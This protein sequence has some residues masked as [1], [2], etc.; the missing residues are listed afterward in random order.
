MLRKSLIVVWILVILGHRRWEKST[1]QIDE[2]LIFL[3]RRERCVQRGKDLGWIL[4]NMIVENEYMI[5][6]FKLIGDAK[7]WWKEWCWEQPIKGSIIT[8]KVIKD[9]I[10]KRYLP[11][12]H[13]TLKMNK[14]YNLTQKHL[15]MDAYYSKFVKL[16]RHSANDKTPRHESLFA[17]LKPS[18]QP[19]PWVHE[20]WQ[21]TKCNP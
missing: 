10:K 11:L 19:L 15:S 17:R 3:L 16:K 4:G 8:W 5:A 13:E 1:L 21:P 18:P 9:A 2:A 6:W 12:D 14:F 7:I 20:T